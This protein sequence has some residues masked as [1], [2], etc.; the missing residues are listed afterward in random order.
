MCNRTCAGH[1]VVANCTRCAEAPSMPEGPPR[2][3]RGSERSGE[4]WTAT[5][6]APHSHARWPARRSR[7]RP[8]RPG[9]EG[10]TPRVQN[11]AR[12][13]V[14][15]RSRSRAARCQRT[16][17]AGR[18]NDMA[19]DKNLTGTSWRER[20]HPFRR[21]ATPRAR[22]RGRSRHDL[23]INPRRRGVQTGGTLRRPTRARATTSYCAES[24][25]A[26]GR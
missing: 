7:Q 11:A 24:G 18:E 2:C 10:R 16:T 20:P 14:R 13:V 9:H 1:R 12:R 19:S 25:L 8:A 4:H 15:S 3:C 26:C 17:P 23:L 22:C 21:G 6:T 5:S